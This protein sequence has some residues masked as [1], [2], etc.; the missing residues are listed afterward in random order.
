MNKWVNLKDRRLSSN[1]TDVGLR[2]EPNLE[3][4]AQIEPDLIIGN[5]DNNGP[6]YENLN[7]IAP[8]LLFDPNPSEQEN[9]SGFERMKNQ[10]MIIADV[11]HRH[12]QGVAILERMNQKIAE[13]RANVHNRQESIAMLLFLSFGALCTFDRLYYRFFQ[14]SFSTQLK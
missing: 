10:F 9:V 13:G 11:L 4:T 3:V 5:T 2:S 12:D 1:V 6:I 8:T 14:S 7:A